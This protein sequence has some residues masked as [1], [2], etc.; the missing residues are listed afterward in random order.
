VKSER[1]K[2]REVRV[3]SQEERGKEGENGRR[4]R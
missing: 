4:I 3:K 2:R 1:R